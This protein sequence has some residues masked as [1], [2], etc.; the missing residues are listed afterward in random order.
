MNLDKYKKLVEG[1]EKKDVKFSVI[2]EDDKKRDI[3]T[4]AF[5][6]NI[7]T[8]YKSIILLVEEKLYH[9]ALALV[10]VIFDAVI[11]GHY[12]YFAFDDDK[13][14]EFYE[15][16]NWDN[17]KYF[18]GNMQTMCKWLDEKY[19]EEIYEPMRETSY[20]MMN[21]FTHTGNLAIAS[22]FTGNEIKPN[23]D[24]ES[25]INL[26]DRLHNLVRIF[27]IFL[28]SHTFLHNKLLT[29]EEINQFME[30]SKIEYD[31]VS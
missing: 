14:V 11:R 23:I 7:K 3:L 24:D 20:K 25:I 13:I 31:F 2:L 17:K 16:E 27:Y 9:S 28:F 15:S 4:V 21:D 22:N 5:A 6:E 8:H 18:K 26:L 30:D 19:G 10:R 29:N 1:I 12:V